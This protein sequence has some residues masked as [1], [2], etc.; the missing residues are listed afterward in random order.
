L[1]E[2]GSD[3]AAY[4]GTNE[5]IR[6]LEEALEQIANLVSGLITRA[7]VAQKN[8]ATSEVRKAATAHT[9]FMRTQAQYNNELSEL[10]KYVDPLK[11]KIEIGKQFAKALM[12]EIE[13]SRITSRISILTSM[14]SKSPEHQII[15]RA[16]FAYLEFYTLDQRSELIEHSKAFNIVA[17]KHTLEHQE[18]QLRNFESLLANEDQSSAN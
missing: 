17:N 6:Q 1:D 14:K 8:N 15:A 13:H 5:R 3:I 11:D 10:R 18:E 2:V 4:D 7:R 12:S 16:A 9:E